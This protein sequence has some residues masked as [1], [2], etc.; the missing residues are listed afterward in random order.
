MMTI[1]LLKM[2]CFVFAEYLHG[3]DE[4]SEH[5]LDETVC[6][7]C[8]SHMHESCSLEFRII[9]GNARQFCRTNCEYMSTFWLQVVNAYAYSCQDEDRHRDDLREVQSMPAEEQCTK[10]ILRRT[11]TRVSLTCRHVSKVQ[12]NFLRL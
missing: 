3:I 8:H 10:G 12:K 7:L 5:M 9:I 1:K 6:I 11:G 4:S 2:I